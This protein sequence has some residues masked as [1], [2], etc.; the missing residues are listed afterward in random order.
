MDQEAHGSAYTT[1]RRD[2][3]KSLD[4]TCRE[5]L[6]ARWSATA[7]HH[8]P[9]ARWTDAPFAAMAWLFLGRMALFALCSG[10]DDVSRP[11]FKWGQTKEKVFVTVAVRN[12]N[13][14]SV[15][16]RFAADRLRFQCS[17]I[18]GKA[19]ALDLELD[20][21]VAPDLSRWELP[22]RKERWGEP[23]LMTLTKIFPAAWPALV[24]DPQNYRQV[25]DRDWSRDDDK[26]ETAEDAFFEEHADFSLECFGSLPSRQSAADLD[27]CWPRAS[28]AGMQIFVKTLTGKTITLDVEASDTIDNVKAK[29]QD[30]EGIPPDQQRLIFAGKQLEDGR[31]LS[32][33]NIQKESTLHLVLRLR[34]GCCW[35]FSFLIILTII[36]MIFLMPCT[37]GTSACLIPFLIPPLLVLPC[38]CL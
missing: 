37:C 4:A 6:P 14:S 38:F 19:F 34:G 1:N 27:A 18:D 25:M 8:S 22:S 11:H 15:S 3:L 29:I 17:D 24:H 16:V 21:D 31:T 7:T 28:T 23:V 33:Y 30:K 2:N 13:R 32:D 10:Q 35:F 12:L 36:S 9:F 26:L 20:Q 5:R